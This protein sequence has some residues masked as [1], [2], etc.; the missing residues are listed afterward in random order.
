[1][2]NFSR[3]EKVQH[4]HLIKTKVRI[5]NKYIKGYLYTCKRM[6]TDDGKERDIEIVMGFPQQLIKST[7]N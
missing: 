7:K 1:M 3:R 2:F 6:A 4:W 5:F